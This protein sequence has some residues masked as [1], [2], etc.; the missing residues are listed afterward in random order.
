MNNISTSGKRHWRFVS[1][2]CWRC[3]HNVYCVY[4]YGGSVVRACVFWS[5]PSTVAVWGI[6][7]QLNHEV[8]VIKHSWYNWR[9]FH[10]LWDIL[11]RLFLVTHR[12]WQMHNSIPVVGL[13][14]KTK[15]RKNSSFSFVI[16]VIQMLYAGQVP[17]YLS[18][19]CRLVDR[20]D[21]RTLEPASFHIT[22]M[23]IAVSLCFVLGNWTLYRRNFVKF[24]HFTSP[25]K[26]FY[27]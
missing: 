10:A 21:R 13:W 24:E 1:I 5:L 18:S 17:K 23:G 27:V 6:G 26:N 7:K 16:H 19:D 14:S 22:F 11:R 9:S 3:A 15:S 2:D 4:G 20:F 25:T 12:G 8:L